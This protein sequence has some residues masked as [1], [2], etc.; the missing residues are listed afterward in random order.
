MKYLEYTSERLFLY[1][2][3]SYFHTKCAWLTESHAH[4]LDFRQIGRTR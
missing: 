3:A 1:P 4:P 2:F